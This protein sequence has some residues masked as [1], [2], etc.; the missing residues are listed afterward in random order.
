MA[1]WEADTMVPET[2]LAGVEGT[3]A[4]VWLSPSEH[5][6]SAPVRANHRPTRATH[7]FHRYMKILIV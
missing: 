3:T 1:M 4:A 2:E 7:P 5:A 6:A